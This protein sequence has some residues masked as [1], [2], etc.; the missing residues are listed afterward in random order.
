MCPLQEKKKKKSR[1]YELLNFSP[2]CTT[3]HHV[4]WKLQ[5]IKVA[6]QFRQKKLL[7]E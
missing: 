7:Q 2:A 4:G 3:T 6:K 1:S 5:L